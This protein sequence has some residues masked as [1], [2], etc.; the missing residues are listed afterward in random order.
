MTDAVEVGVSKRQRAIL[1]KWVRCKAET[2]YRLVERSRIILLSADGVANAE[3]ARQLGVD[4][5]RV[6]RWRGRWSAAEERLRAAEQEGA[7]D[8]D[9]TRLL[10][11]VLA[12]EQR[13][14]APSTFSAEQLTRI[15]AVACELPEDSGRPVTHWTPRELADEVIDRGIVDTISPRHVDRILKGGTC[16]HT[17]AATGSRRRT[18]W[19]IRPNTRP[20]YARS[21]RRT[22]TPRPFTKTVATW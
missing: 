18:S 22:Q 8:R 13:S 3:Q 14:G 10:G 15:I 12:D 1:T 2:P 6:R 19:R 21:A 17:R 11:S 9:L 7:N 16:A 20:M 5:Q 4:R